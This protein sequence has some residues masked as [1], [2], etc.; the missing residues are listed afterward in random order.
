[1]H[2]RFRAGFAK[3]VTN[4]HCWV[5][6]PLDRMLTF[7]LPTPL[8]SCSAQVMSYLQRF[9]VLSTGTAASSIGGR[10][11]AAGHRLGSSEADSD[12]C[13]DDEVR[14][15]QQHVQILLVCVLSGG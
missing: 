7:W 3:V 6:T 8:H 5:M 9:K 14:C 15:A 13:S 10:P 4:T 1:M 2:W 12:D 11:G